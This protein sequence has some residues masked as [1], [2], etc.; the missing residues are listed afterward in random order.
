MYLGCPVSKI[1]EYK[2]VVDEN[3]ASTVEKNEILGTYISCLYR[4]EYTP[5]GFKR[6][7]LMKTSAKEFATEGEAVDFANEVVSAWELNDFWAKMLEVPRKS[8][9]MLLINKSK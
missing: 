1:P 2:K 4:Y 9:Q 5:S 7:L 3:F 6:P 8:V